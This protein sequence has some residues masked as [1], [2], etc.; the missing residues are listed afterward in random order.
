MK[1]SDHMRSD[2]L[3]VRPEA[4]V[5]DLAR[6]MIG[7]GSRQAVV[8]DSS[9]GVV[10][11]VTATDLI[12]KHARLH[13]PT[14]FSLLGFSIPI[15]NHREEH[16][17]EQALATTAGDLMSTSLVTIPPE[18]DVDDAASLMLDNEV[19]CLPVVQDG[20]LLGTIDET[21]IVRLLVVEEA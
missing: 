8:V 19:S 11:I 4:S 9:G 7:R 3:T 17:I 2:T 15:E 16:E 12:A 13:F 1:V 20:E 21:D 18:A 14:Y 5:G 6:A 10:G